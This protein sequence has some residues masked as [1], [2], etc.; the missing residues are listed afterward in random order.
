[1]SV[2]ASMGHF[3]VSARDCSGIVLC[4]CL[5]GAILAPSA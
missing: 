4:S 1:V 3:N 2:S 5:G